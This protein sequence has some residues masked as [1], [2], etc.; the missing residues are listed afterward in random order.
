RQ[1]LLADLVFPAHS[2]DQPHPGDVDLVED[3]PLVALLGQDPAV[4]H[5]L[6]ELGDLEPGDIRQHRLDPHHD[7][8][9]LARGSK[10]WLGVQPSRKRSSS[11]SSALP[12]ITVRWTYWSPGVPDAG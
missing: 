12:S 9:I 3:R 6:L 2:P 4:L 7:D 5:P 8:T 1:R 10:G 11:G